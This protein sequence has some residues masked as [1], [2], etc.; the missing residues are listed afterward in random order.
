MDCVSRLDGQV[1]IV[2]VVFG[3]FG[4]NIN[5]YSGDAYLW[6]VRKSGG[7]VGELGGQLTLTLE[8]KYK[9]NVNFNLGEIEF[10]LLM[11][12]VPSTVLLPC[13]Y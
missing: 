12:R 1:F 4:E 9:Q 11:V 2:T 8:D 3:D 6:L 5:K 7:F 10:D 13:L